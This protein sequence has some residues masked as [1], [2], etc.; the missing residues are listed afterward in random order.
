MKAKLKSTLKKLGI[1]A[2]YDLMKSG[3][4]NELGWFRSYREEKPVD[5][6][7]NPTPWMTYP[8]IAFLEKRIKPEMTVFEYGSGNSTLWWAERV[9]FVISC[10][11]NRQWYEQVKKD[12]P[13][14]VELHYVE[15]K[16][17]GEYCEK[18]IKYSGKLDLVVID[19]RDRV[20]CARN[21]LKALKNEGVII[22]DN[23]DRDQ[24]NEGY[25]LLLRNGYKRLDFTGMGPINV[26]SW[27]TS[28]FYRKLNCLG[29]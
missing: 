25:S 20:N 18:I 28:L 26:Q 3:A 7:G 9:K 16:K 8:A 10:E 15:L 14:N 24:Y 29:L 11:H 5:K 19:G 6:D 13:E 12:I 1:Y 22:W 17:G 2:S 21:S 23:S 27:C 4:L